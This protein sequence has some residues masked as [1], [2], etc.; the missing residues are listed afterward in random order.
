MIDVTHDTT[1]PKNVV[2]KFEKVSFDTWL[3]SM[4]GPAIEEVKGKEREALHE[5]WE[6]IKLPRRATVGSVGY[7]FFSPL[8]VYPL[9]PLQDVT[10]PTGIK[11]KLEPG[12]A[13]VMAPKS[14]LG[15]RYH[16]TLS[17]TLGIIDSDYYDCE[18]TEG[19]IMINIANGLYP[20]PREN[21]ITHKPEIPPEQIMNIGRGM[22]FLQGIILPIGYAY[23]EEEVTATRTGGF[24]STMEQT[25]SQ[26][27]EPES[28]IRRNIMMT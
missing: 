21:M 2:A 20:M 11:C 27:D 12:W 19:Q 1:E 26:N 14:G 16:T 8:D 18:E 9:P 15:M 22:A 28:E 6:N 13:L 5:I 25:P 17:G 3:K 10:I 23:E 7:D 24:G 4:M